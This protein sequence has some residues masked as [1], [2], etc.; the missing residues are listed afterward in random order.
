MVGLCAYP[1]ASP[2]PQTLVENARRCAALG[3]RN[4]S[5]YN[6]GIMTFE[7]LSWVAK[8]VKAAKEV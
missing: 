5:F 3:V 1:P 7:H 6:Y 4:L 8:A 2:D